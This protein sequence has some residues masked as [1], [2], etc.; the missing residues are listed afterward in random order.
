MELERALS[1]AAAWPLWTNQPIVLYHGTIRR[2]GESIVRDGVDV[3][4]GLPNTDFGRGF[5]TTTSCLQAR[6]FADRKSASKNA[7][8]AITKFTLDR[9]TLGT[10]RGLVFLRGSVDAVDYWSFVAHCRGRRLGALKANSGYDVVYGPVARSWWG[11]NRSRVYANYDQIS[12]HGDKAQE[13]LRD[14]ILC[15]IEVIE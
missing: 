14:S 7:P 6:A 15:R 11:P 5:Y 2:F 8:A 10:L 13:L 3:A 12:F 9:L 4:R 1:G